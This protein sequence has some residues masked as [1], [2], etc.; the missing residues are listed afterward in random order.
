MNRNNPRIQAQRQILQQ[1]AETEFDTETYTGEFIDGNWK[2][3]FHYHQGIEA[4]RRV[5]Q[6]ALWK[7][8]EEESAWRGQE[9]GQ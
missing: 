3:N 9:T 8:D 1:L 2:P 6:Q 5:I 4:Y 7:L